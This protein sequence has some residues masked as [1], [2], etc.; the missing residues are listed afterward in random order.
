MKSGNGTIIG[1]ILVVIVLG[2]I[3]FLMSN[4]VITVNNEVVTNTEKEEVTTILKTDIEIS[5]IKE[6]ILMISSTLGAGN[7]LNTEDTYRKLINFE[8]SKN[9]SYQIDENFDVIQKSLK[10]INKD[11]KTLHV[12]INTD[13]YINVSFNM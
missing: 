9:S 5:S 12:T 13:N 1:L 2:L 6:R 11:G 7:D 10:V 4:N 8:L 3:L